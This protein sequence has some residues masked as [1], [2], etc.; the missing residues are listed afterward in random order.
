MWLMFKLKWA[1]VG[2]CK[3]SSLSLHPPL[4]PA[5]HLPLLSERLVL[6]PLSTMYPCSG[7]I[8]VFMWCFWQPVAAPLLMWSKQPTICPGLPLLTLSF[9]NTA[10]QVH[11]AYSINP[12]MSTS[13]STLVYNAN[14]LSL[15]VIVLKSESDSD[16]KWSVG[17]R[18][19]GL[20][21]ELAV[22][23]EEALLRLI[24]VV[25]LVWMCASTGVGLPKPAAWSIYS[26]SVYHTYRCC[27]HQ[28]P[29]IQA[30]CSLPTQSCRTYTFHSAYIH[31]IHEW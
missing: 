26:N 6:C 13:A 25:I 11:I 18:Q 3:I 31:R 15:S 14:S 5:Q 24:Q 9:G 23:Q 16:T 7:V 10:L 28:I 1:I 12:I 29:I 2:L 4:S 27:L 22:H 21:L 19:G 20:W 30:V 17:M 8:H